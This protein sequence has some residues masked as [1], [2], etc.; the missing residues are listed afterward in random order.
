MVATFLKNYANNFGQILQGTLQRRLST[1]TLYDI[2]LSTLPLHIACYVI[3][4]PNNFFSK[5][6]LDHFFKYLPN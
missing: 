1:S 6:K 5:L 3:M 4:V 2:C